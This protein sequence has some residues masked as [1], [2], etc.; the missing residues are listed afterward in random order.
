MTDLSYFAVADPASGAMTFWRSNSDGRLTEWPARTG[1]GPVLWTKPGIG[2]D[3]VTP[4]E[5]E[6]AARFEWVQN[7][8]RTVR[9]P[10]LAEIKK[11]V[12]ANPVEAS[13]RFA[14]LQT[15]C[16]RCG[17]HLEDAA[18][19]A[20]ALGSDCVTRFSPEY[21]AALTREVGR[22]LAAR[23]AGDEDGA[24][25]DRGTAHGDA[26]ARVRD[27]ERAA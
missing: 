5:L 3:H 16:A 6:G 18:S 10:W 12:E 1:Y 27:E 25:I 8:H 23:E 19:R 24:L 21:V 22:A 9:W 7:W 20:R 15:A 14:A 11:A 2:R 17:R 26:L 13:A 4:A